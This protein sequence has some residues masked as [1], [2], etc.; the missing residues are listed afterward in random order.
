LGLP[1][2]SFT[3]TPTL[4]GLRL[5]GNLNYCQ[6][7]NWVLPLGIFFALN[8]GEAASIKLILPEIKNAVA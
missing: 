2:F 1:P 6:E 3:V 7:G 8:V 5:R 4:T